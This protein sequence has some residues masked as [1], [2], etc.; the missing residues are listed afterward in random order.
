MCQ[1][2]SLDTKY[3]Y[4]ISLIHILR[5]CVRVAVNYTIT[6]LCLHVSYRFRGVN[7]RGLVEDVTTRIMCKGFNKLDLLS[8][9]LMSLHMQVLCKIETVYHNFSEAGDNNVFYRLSLFMLETDFY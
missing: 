1:D 7:I 2:E 5:L 9:L 8:Y 6:K 3:F 4:L